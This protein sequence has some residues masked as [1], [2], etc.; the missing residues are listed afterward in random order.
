M[1]FHIFYD[2]RDPKWSTY[3]TYL[4]QA[5]VKADESCVPA[6][7]G[8]LFVVKAKQTSTPSRTKDH[9]SSGPRVLVYHVLRSLRIIH[10]ECYKHKP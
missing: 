10:V 6:M 9:E 8:F 5:R 4:P 2:E 1:L 7:T 3:G